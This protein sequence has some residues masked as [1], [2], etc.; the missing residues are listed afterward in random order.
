MNNT[1][2]IY[3]LK[4]NENKQLNLKPLI[5]KKYDFQVY[6]L[7]YNSNNQLLLYKGNQEYESKIIK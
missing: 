5:M 3:D 2:V 4:E 7:I 1:I 6:S